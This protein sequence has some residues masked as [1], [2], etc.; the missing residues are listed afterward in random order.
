M[1]E[2]CETLREVLNLRGGTWSRFRL[3]P[4]PADDVD[5]TATDK[6]G[7]VLYVQV[8]RVERRAWRQLAEDGASESQ[9]SPDDLAEDIRGAIEAKARKHSPSQRSQL[10]LALDARRS[11][12]HAR[13]VV[14]NAFLAANGPWVTG[15]GY[16]AAW[17]VGPTPDSTHKLC[18]DAEGGSQD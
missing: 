7:Q 18:L 6:D 9:K 11:P 4:P 8:T 1:L 3:K 14:V 17:L 10:V 13:Q 12:G 16:R 15:L 2:T 5:A